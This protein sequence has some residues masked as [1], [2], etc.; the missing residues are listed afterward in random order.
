MPSTRP[1]RTSNLVFRCSD[2]L[3]EAIEYVA[4]LQDEPAAAVV[5]RAVREPLDRRIT[6][7]KRQHE[8]ISASRVGAT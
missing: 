2:D 3:R 8:A 7:F 1:A 4:T 5:R 6:A